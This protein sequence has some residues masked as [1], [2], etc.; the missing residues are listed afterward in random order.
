MDEFEIYRSDF[1]KLSQAYSFRLPGYLILESLLPLT[2]FGDLPPA[3]DADLAKCFRVA[4]RLL[5]AL[6]LPERIYFSRFGE[7]TQAIHFHVVPR[8]AEIARRYCHPAA[9]TPGL[10]GAEVMSWI[11]ANHGDLDYSDADIREFVR[12]ARQYLQ[13]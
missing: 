6:L 8:T 1:Y 12:S 5:N 9:V 2:E 11:W 10:N 7:T 4:E 13:A 3:A